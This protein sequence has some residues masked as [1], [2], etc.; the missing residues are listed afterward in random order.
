MSEKNITEQSQTL[1]LAFRSNDKFLP[2]AVFMLRKRLY[3]KA[4]QEPQFR[5]YAL[6]DRIYRPDVLAAAWKLVAS[7]DG[8]PGVDGVT[9]KQVRDLH[10]GVEGFLTGIHE[11]LKSKRYKPQ[12]IKRVYIPKAGGKQRP[13]GIPTVRDRV[14]QMA[15][16]LVLEPIFEADFLEVSYG[17]RP[18]RSA[19]EAVQ[20]IHSGLARGKDAIYDADLK[21]FFDSIPH[22]KLMACVEMRVSDRSVLKLIRQW[23]N[24]PILELSKDKHHP[25]KK[26]RHTKGT[27]QGGVISPLLANIY[28]HWLDK[29][30]HDSDGPA[31]FAGAE[32]VRYADDFVILARYQGNRIR[33][34]VEA[35][36]EDWMGLEI[37]REKTKVVRLR[38]AGAELDY[39]SYSFSYLPDRFGRKTRYLSHYPSSKSCA[40]ERD[41]I[42]EVLSSRHSFVPIPDLIASLNRQLS[43]WGMYFSQGHSRRRLR[44]MNWFVFNRVVKH[45][46]RRSQR[47]Y[48]PPEGVSWYSHV[49]DKLG[50]VTL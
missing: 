38:E 20:A 2:E 17:Y 31:R 34:W 13:L 9:I 43:G 49:H 22:D 1:P 23:L 50:L 32:M 46:K 24:A 18:K 44:Q 47:P 42:R 48:R 25:P 16:K 5:F 40:E 21:G 27:P 35:T 3:I 28:L 37:N 4:K 8:G 36:V 41:V 12:T 26:I 11:A 30:F 10:C 15:A 33:D 14:V 6:Y 19:L 7:N 45:L 29:R 39:L